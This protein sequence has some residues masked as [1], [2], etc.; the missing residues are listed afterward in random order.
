MHSDLPIVSI[1][2]PAYNAEKYIAESIRSILAQSYENWELIVVNDG[3]IDSTT[4]V[5]ASFDDSRI[6]IVEQKN[7]GVSAAR[8]TGIDLAKGKY[9]TFLDAD[10]TIPNYSIED[11]VMYLETYDNIDAVHG[12]ISIRDEFLKEETRFYEPFVYQNLL[13]MSLHLD[14]CLF[15]TPGYMLRNEKLNAIRF[16]EG[17][18]H[19]EDVL[20]FITLCLNNFTFGHIPKTM[21][22]YRESSSSAMSNMKGWRQGYFDLLRNLKT[23]PSVSYAD[24]FVM[25]LKVARMFASWRI[26]SMNLRGLTDVIKIFIV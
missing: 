12:S 22:H 24:T 10:D 8:N 16:K 6:W 23:L 1:I 11:R 17:M 2:I 9:I 3:S 19:A 18:T 26:K 13:K 14:S 25:R 5:V 21:Y 4:K 7:S 15:F 20:F